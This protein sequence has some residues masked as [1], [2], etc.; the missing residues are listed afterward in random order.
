MNAF[1]SVCDFPVDRP[2]RRRAA[3]SWWQPAYTPDGALAGIH[4]PAHNPGG[5]CIGCIGVVPEARGHGY[6]YGLLV[7]CTRFLAEHG[8]TPV[9][10][11]TDRDNVPTA[12]AF[13]RTGTASWRSASI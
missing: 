1:R 3:R 10:G 8:A 5:P 7:E 2:A 4:V 12:A 11:A 6:G 13:A 9:A